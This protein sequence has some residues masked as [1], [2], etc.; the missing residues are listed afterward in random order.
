MF[1]IIFGI[2]APS[3]QSCKI[4]KYY[5][6]CGICDLASLD[7]IGLEVIWLLIHGIAISMGIVLII[8]IYK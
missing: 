4:G 1:F 3:Y 5:Y 8:L 7:S 6:Y 2:F